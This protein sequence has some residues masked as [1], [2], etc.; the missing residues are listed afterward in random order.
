M[1]NFFSKC[2]AEIDKKCNIN[3]EILVVS[4]SKTLLNTKP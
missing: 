1:H 4:N 3:I 2:N